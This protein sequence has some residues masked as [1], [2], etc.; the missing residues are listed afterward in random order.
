MYYKTIC[1]NDCVHKVNGACKFSY[2]LRNSIF[3]TEK[4]PCIYYS[5]KTKAKAAQ[6]EQDLL[7]HTPLF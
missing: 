2:H 4:M 7:Y 1:K 3:C 5:S 6:N